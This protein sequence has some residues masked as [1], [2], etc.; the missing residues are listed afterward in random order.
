VLG[1]GPQIHPY[2]DQPSRLLIGPDCVIRENAT[3]HRGSSRGNL[4][5]VV[6]EACFIMDS[7][8]VGHDCELE[9]GVVLARGA[10]LGG[11]SWVGEGVY[12]GGLAAVHQWTRIGRKAFIGGLTPLTRDVVPYAM[13]NGNPCH[14]EGLNYR[15][16]RREG[17]DRHHLRALRAAYALAFGDSAGSLSERLKSTSARYGHIPEIRDI[18]SFAEAPSKRGLCLPAL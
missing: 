12:I 1:G 7:A 14:M 8:H 3:L 5:T 9:K 17:A 11:H 15:G 2:D 10:T 6:G 13:V 4:E 18:L 16:F